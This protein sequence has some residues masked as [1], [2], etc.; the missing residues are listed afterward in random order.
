MGGFSAGLSPVKPADPQTI[1]AVD[2]SRAELDG[3]T[4]GTLTPEALIAYVAEKLGGID[5]RV[6]TMMS[7]QRAREAQSQAL[8]DLANVLGAHQADIAE[9]ASG[10]QARKDIDAA[11]AKAIAAVG[12][13]DTPLGQK[14]AAQRKDFDGTAQLNGVNVGDPSNLVNTKE[15]DGF[16]G[17]VN[18]LQSDLNRGGELDM[19]QLQSMTSQR[20]QIVQMATNVIASLGETSK[21][22]AQKIG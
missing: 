9:G 4:Y 8:T 1:A 12:G 2:A 21:A 14:L 18:R 17:N 11:Y 19:L 13:E 3:L 16:L 20:Q 7:K 6:Q 5:N 10:D 15:M 22:I